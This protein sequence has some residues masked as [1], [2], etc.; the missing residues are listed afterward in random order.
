QLH[1]LATEALTTEEKRRAYAAMQAAV[2]P[3]LAR[4][5]LALSLGKE[6]SV[7]ESTKNVA[8]VAA[9][10]H[11]ALAW[12]FARANMDALL[13]QVTFFGRNEYVPAIMKPFSDAARADELDEYVRNNFPP[14]AAAEAA[15]MSDRIRHFAIVK[16]RE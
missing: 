15:R 13:Q 2:D 10:D 5:T 16:Q 14:G 6:M 3:A 7:T 12:D 8:R 4:D 11:V 1:A 9:A